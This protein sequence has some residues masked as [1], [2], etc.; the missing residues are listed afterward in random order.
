MKF[1][2][3]VWHETKDSFIIGPCTIN[4]AE[5][6]LF[7]NKAGQPFK[8][9]DRVE[10]DVILKPAKAGASITVPDFEKEKKS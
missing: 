8:L 1:L 2:G 6:C 4:D 9:L 5:F 10:I 3:K 7:L